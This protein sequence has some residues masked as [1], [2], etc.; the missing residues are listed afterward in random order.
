MLWLSVGMIPV[1][2]ATAI[3]DSCGDTKLCS[4]GQT[5]SDSPVGVCVASQPQSVSNVTTLINPLKAGTSLSSFLTDILQFVITIGSVV[6]VL[7][8]VFVGYKF[9]TAQGAPDKIKDAK[10]M[11]LWTLIGALVL[12]GAQAIAAAIQATVTALGG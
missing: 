9:V 3:G 8:V 5:C 11:L 10:Q 6:I 12:L 1:A 7:M 2:Y 4:S